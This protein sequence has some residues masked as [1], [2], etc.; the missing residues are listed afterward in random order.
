MGIFHRLCAAADGADVFGDR[1]CHDLLHHRGLRGLDARYRTD[2]PEP[3]RGVSAP[4]PGLQCALDGRAARRTVDGLSCGRV[5]ADPARGMVR[6]AWD[7]NMKAIDCDVHPTVT[8][9]DILLP[10]LETY[11][12]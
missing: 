5:C 12:R 9:N 8:G 7:N 1:V 6:G 3:G 4:H 2:R 11:W 10:Y